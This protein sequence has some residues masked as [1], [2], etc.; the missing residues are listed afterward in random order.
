[1]SAIYRLLE[2]V[3]KLAYLNL[4][5]IVF[6]M[7]GFVVAGLFPATAATFTVSRDWVMGKGDIKIWPVFWNAYK[8]S[9]V[10]SNILG[11]FIALVAYILYLDFFFLTVTSS[12]YALLLTIPF[13]SFS[14]LFLLTTC[15]AFPV[16]VYYQMTVWQVIKSAFVIMIVNPLTTLMIVFGQIGILTILWHFQGL[17]IFFSMSVSSISFMIPAKRAFQHVHARHDKK[18]AIDSQ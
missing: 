9:F 12:Q 1:M 16:Y 3:T 4:L 15:Y 11:Y 14:L 8:Q 5:W 17:M 10:S 6:S 13:L 2:W 7:L 18:V